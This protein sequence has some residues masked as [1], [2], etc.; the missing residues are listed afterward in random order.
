MRDEEA[1]CVEAVS[2]SWELVQ[3]LSTNANDFW[4]ALKGFIST[5][6]HHKLLQLTKAQS[7]TLAATLKQVIHLTA[8]KKRDRHLDFENVISIM[9]Y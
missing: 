5:A 4:P 1:L 3:G 6:F 7:P 9:K 2:L 8:G